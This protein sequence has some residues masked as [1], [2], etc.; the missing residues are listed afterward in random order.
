MAQAGAEGGAGMPE[1]RVEEVHEEVLAEAREVGEEDDGIDERFDFAG[2]ES[3]EGEGA[4]AD[5]SRSPKKMGGGRAA[6]GSSGVDARAR[7]A[8][9]PPLPSLE[10][11]GVG[12]GREGAGFTARVS[13]LL[14]GAPAAS[15]PA[16]R[17]AEAVEG[18][19]EARAA[20]A[21]GGEGVAG[22]G[23]VDE[24]S[25]GAL[26]EAAG[27][28]GV[29]G[30]VAM[31]E[32]SGGSPPELAAATA[33]RC[34]HESGAAVR[35]GKAREATVRFAIRHGAP[36]TDGQLAA[37]RELGTVRVFT[38]ATRAVVEERDAAAAQATAAAA[39]AEKSA[40]VVEL[41]RA[42][43]DGSEGA[44]ERH[45]RELLAER[46]ARLFREQD[47][48]ALA[49][50][51]AHAGPAVEGV[52]REALGGSGPPPAAPAAARA[53]P[54]GRAVTHPLG[55]SAATTAVR[56]PAALDVSVLPGGA[57]ARAREIDAILRARGAVPLAEAR[58]FFRLSP[59]AAYRVGRLH[60]LC[61]KC[62]QP[63]HW[64]SR[65]AK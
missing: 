32:G 19:V 2:D 55:G 9:V 44:A 63:G 37:A 49:R 47:F 15:P 24:G 61:A 4:R 60:D 40:V 46:A 65:C 50:L 12:T 57:A 18:G 8:P 39:E 42:A 54:T 14:F 22:V 10:D 27:G 64:A 56:A 41:L 45:A 48:G 36:Y 38:V 33:E 62:L 17:E 26:P 43:L 31:D 23:A 5:R 30:G 28:E 6:G 59:G 34:R 21:A 20:E 51:T 16:R 1:E 7:L 3:S 11:A 35:R 58:A 29:A 13:S 52:V 53:A 25:G